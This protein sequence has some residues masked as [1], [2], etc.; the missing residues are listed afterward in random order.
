MADE[1]EIAFSKLDLGVRARRP[2]PPRFDHA[3]F[4]AD[5]DRVMSWGRPIEA[6]RPS[7]EV[8]RRVQDA[9]HWVPGI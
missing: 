1:Q 2:G 4:R 7:Y 6:L 9:R 8:L 3:A 5:H